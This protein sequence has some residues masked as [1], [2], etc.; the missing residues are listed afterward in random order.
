[1]IPPHSTFELHRLHVVHKDRQD[2]ECKIQ[3]HGFLAF[4]MLDFHEIELALRRSEA[5]ECED[6]LWFGGEV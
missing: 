4:F 5:G 3:I 6:G 1:M 2:I